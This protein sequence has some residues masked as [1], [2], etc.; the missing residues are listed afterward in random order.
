MVLLDILLNKKYLHSQDFINNAKYDLK[1]E[2]NLI[3]C[4]NWNNFHP[5]TVIFGILWFSSPS[6]QHSLP[7][8]K[9]IL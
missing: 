2:N 4:Q 7:Y 8:A 3:F 5:E 6:R 1:S 9:Q